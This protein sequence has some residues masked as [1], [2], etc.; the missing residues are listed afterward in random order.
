MRRFYIGRLGH[1]QRSHRYAKYPEPLLIAFIRARA[2]GLPTGSVPHFC[3]RNTA[4]V[5]LAGRLTTDV[6]IQTLLC[7]SHPQAS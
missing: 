6:V 2:A 1:T 4:F 3:Q 7:Q 5:Q